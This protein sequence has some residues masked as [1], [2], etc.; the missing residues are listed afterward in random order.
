MTA[1]AIDTALAKPKRAIPTFATRIW[2]WWRVGAPPS[3]APSKRRRSPPV[4]R[5]SEIDAALSR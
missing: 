2:F 3:I 1:R 5:V 4:A